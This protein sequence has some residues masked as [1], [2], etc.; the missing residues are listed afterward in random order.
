MS[1]ADFRYV[2][3]NTVVRDDSCAAKAFGSL[4]LTDQVVTAVGTT[5]ELGGMTV[6]YGNVIADAT[7]DDCPASL[8]ENLPTTLYV[9]GIGNGYGPR[10]ATVTGG[11]G[12]WS[13]GNPGGDVGMPCAYTPASPQGTWDE[14]T[15]YQQDDVVRVPDGSGTDCTTMCGHVYVAIAN[16]PT[17]G[18]LDPNTEWQEIFC[19]EVNDDGCSVS[20]NAINGQ[21]VVQWQD[22]G[23]MC[24]P[25]G[26]GTGQ[27]HE[28]YKDHGN[29]PTGTYANG[30]VVSE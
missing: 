29:C 30:V 14:N 16:P 27:S 22:C 23:G 20:F 8:G 21:W 6:Y 12:S 15:Q 24:D 9:Y 7:C 11:G 17:M 10:T 5:S 3:L 18:I 28:D 19:T 1:L 26:S 4:L 2:Y 13:T 25:Y